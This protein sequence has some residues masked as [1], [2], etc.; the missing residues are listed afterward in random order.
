MMERFTAIK[1]H[2]TKWADPKRLS[3]LAMMLSD[4]TVFLQ[5]RQKRD[6]NSLRGALAL[7]GFLL[8]MF[9]WLLSTVLAPVKIE[10]PSVPNFVLMSILFVF[11]TALAGHLALKIVGVKSTYKAVVHAIFY[12]C[13]PIPIFAAI[14]MGVWYQA[15]VQNS[16]TFY[17][18]L[19]FLTTLMLYWVFH[20]WRALTITLGGTR[21]QVTLSFFLAFFLNLPVTFLFQA[22]S[23][24]LGTAT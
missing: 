24:F 16:L 19:I 6:G 11:F 13:G 20:S 23:A 18:A 2:I 7:Y 4:T 9:L 5:Q 1:R 10:M 17:L 15:T 8:L 22:M 14:G 3:E 21:T 12:L